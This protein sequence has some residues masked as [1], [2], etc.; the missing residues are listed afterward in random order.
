MAKINKNKFI[1][2]GL[3]YSKNGIYVDTPDGRFLTNADAVLKVLCG[4]VPTT[5]LNHLDYQLDRD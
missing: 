4:D 1:I 3:T 5:K 2:L